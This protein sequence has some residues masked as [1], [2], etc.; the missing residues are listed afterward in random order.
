MIETIKEWRIWQ[1]KQFLRRHVSFNNFKPL[2]LS[3]FQNRKD[4]IFRKQGS[5]NWHAWKPKWRLKLKWLKPFSDYGYLKATRS[6]EL[7]LP[8]WKTVNSDYSSDC[9]GTYS[10][11][12]WRS[13]FRPRRARVLGLFLPDWMILVSYNY[14]SI[15]EYLSPLEVLRIFSRQQRPRFKSKPKRWLQQLVKL[16]LW[17]CPLLCTHFCIYKR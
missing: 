8:F 14:Q 17:W 9:T 7:G 5:T 10:S 1:I 4:C 15:S 6:A 2:E 13:A 12:T 11:C 16:A 3:S